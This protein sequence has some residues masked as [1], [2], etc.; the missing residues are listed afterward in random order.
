MAPKAIPKVALDAPLTPE[1]AQAALASAQQLLKSFGKLKNLDKRKAGGAGA[2]Y[3]TGS[4]VQ[5]G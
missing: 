1:N 4:V 5:P 2:C 3:S